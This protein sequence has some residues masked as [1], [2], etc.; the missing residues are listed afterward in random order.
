MIVGGSSYRPSSSNPW[1]GGAQ[2]LGQFMFLL[3]QQ[4]EN[5][6]QREMEKGHW[7]RQHAL[8]V[9]RDS[10]DAAKHRAEM[11][12]ARKEQELLDY[13]ASTVPTITGYENRPA[14]TPAI[15][16]PAPA[17][18]V[19][20][21]E[22]VPRRHAQR[23]SATAES[24]SRLYRGEEMHPLEMEK[25]RLDLISTEADIA[26]KQALK[27]NADREFADAAKE[28]ELDLLMQYWGA[29]HKYFQDGYES[30]DDMF[31]KWKGL[32]PDKREDMSHDLHQSLLGMAGRAP[33]K[34]LISDMWD[35]FDSLETR[36]EVQ[37]AWEE[38][39]EKAPPQ[40]M[41]EGEIISRVA[42]LF[43]YQKPEYAGGPVSQGEDRYGWHAYSKYGWWAAV[44]PEFW[45]EEILK[46]T[47]RA[48]ILREP[49]FPDAVR[50]EQEARYAAA[51]ERYKRRLAERTQQ[52]VD[53][54]LDPVDAEGLAALWVRPPKRP[55]DEPRSV[56]DSYPE[57]WGDWYER[58][59]GTHFDFRGDPRDDWN[60]VEKQLWALKTG[61]HPDREPPMLTAEGFRNLPPPDFLDPWDDVDWSD[62]GQPLID[63][64]TGKM[65]PPY[66][67]PGS[68]FLNAVD[69][70]FRGYTPRDR[71][72]TLRYGG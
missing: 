63:P 61:R 52:I 16:P 49:P 46:P 19:P 25:E 12:E 27:R 22:D 38:F 13:E 31:E 6:K 40:Q 11:L 34:Q 68:I 64:V 39:N 72:D 59:I 53:N 7:D 18:R 55:G 2:A 41:I 51:Q 4:M 30:F 70:L 9:S 26:Y 67:I 58:P 48:M 45:H 60:A 14:D 69:A 5:K 50:N 24:Q 23:A 37:A 62:P 21:I 66:A 71:A 32:P 36:G 44:N 56:V 28:G 15:G 10:R 1:V 17:R 43:Y 3:S 47:Y 29:N 57:L 42:N 20:V 33:N 8:M 65:I 35:L 54:G